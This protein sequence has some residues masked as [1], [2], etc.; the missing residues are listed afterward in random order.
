MVVV[1]PT[2]KQFVE[3]TALKAHLN[4]DKL[5]TRFHTAFLAG[6]KIGKTLNCTLLGNTGTLGLN[7]EF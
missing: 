4:E 7:Y 3:H 1:F 2:I 5:P 6:D